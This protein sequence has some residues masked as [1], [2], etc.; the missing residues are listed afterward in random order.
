MSNRPSKPALEAARRIVD[1]IDAHV[2]DERKKQGRE[3]DWRLYLLAC[4]AGAR[5]ATEIALS[6]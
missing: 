4:R 6:K 1:A 5:I 3:F 2:A